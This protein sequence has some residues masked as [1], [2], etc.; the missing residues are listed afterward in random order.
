[1]RTTGAHS[2]SP[3][4]FAGVALSFRLVVSSFIRF[5]CRLMP[6]SEAEAA[7]L[8][9]AYIAAQRERVEDAARSAMVGS[10]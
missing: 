1:M 4:L 7:Q 6:G 10:A 5:S 9:D 2:H 3:E 8:L